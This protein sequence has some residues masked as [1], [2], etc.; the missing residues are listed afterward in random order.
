MRWLSLVAGIAFVALAF[1]AA[2]RVVDTRDGLIAEVVTLF[3]GL[4]GVSL[5]LYGL[6]A[7]ARPASS[8]GMATP[9]AR[10]PGKP[11]SAR[12]LAIGVGGLGLA[13]ILLGGLLLSA[14]WQWAALGFVILLPMIA[15]SAFLCGRFL[16]AR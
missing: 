10:L 5:V 8:A 12:E 3:S 1:G 16:A 4:A 15:G 14:G 2:T 9:L 7:R 11:P 13:A 6:F